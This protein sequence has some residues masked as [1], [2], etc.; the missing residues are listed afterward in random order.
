MNRPKSGFLT[1]EFWLI[2][3]TFVINVAG[4][5]QNHATGVFAMVAAAIYSVGRS[6]VKAQR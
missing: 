5:A 3:L 6:Y 4:Y 1:S 2:M